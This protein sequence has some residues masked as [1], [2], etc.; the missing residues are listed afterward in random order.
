MQTI[1]GTRLRST[2]GR[3]AL[4]PLLLMLAFAGCDER[5]DLP[6]DPAPKPSTP[7]SLTIVIT[8]ASARIAAI[9]RGDTV[10][11]TATAKDQFGA[12]VTSGRVEWNVEMIPGSAGDIP[13]ELLGSAITIEETGSR[14][15]RIIG[16]FVASAHVTGTIQGAKGSFTVGVYAS[17]YPFI[18][19]PETGMKRI[20]TPDNAP[21]R[22]AGHQ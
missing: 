1:F 14:T 9:K 17:P 10:L 19:S 13:R 12:V 20:P 6:F 4:A 16:H 11:L 8:G 15:A 2:A 21:G 7:A 5:P 3:E 22:G 18:W